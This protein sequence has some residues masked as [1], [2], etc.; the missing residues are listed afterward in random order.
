MCL[1]TISVQNIV[2]IFLE[3][4]V[5][6][7]THVFYLYMPELFFIFCVLVTIWAKPK[8]CFLCEIDWGKPT[9]FLLQ[10]HLLSSSNSI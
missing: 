5:I 3:T 7:M 8:E 4:S 1:H 10:G 6:E 9:I 2:I